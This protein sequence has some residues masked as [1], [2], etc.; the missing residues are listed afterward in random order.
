LLGR[1]FAPSSYRSEGVGRQ[2]VP[3]KP[4]QR[5]YRREVELGHGANSGRSG[6][7]RSHPC[8]GT[9][10]AGD[11]RCSSPG[12]LRSPRWCCQ[13]SGVRRAGARRQCPDGAACD[14]RRERR[15]QHHRHRR[16]AA[17]VARHHHRRPSAR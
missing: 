10:A 1:R 17:C 14:D 4:E 11:D 5:R 6:H 13:R 15:R 2:P 9:S 8:R 16:G 7:L 12:Q 3:S